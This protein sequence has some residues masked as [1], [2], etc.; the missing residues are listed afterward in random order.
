[1]R[2]MKSPLGRPEGICGPPGAEARG[3][4]PARAG[5]DGLKSHSLWLGHVQDGHAVPDVGAH[6]T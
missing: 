4:Q 3:S 5:W 2:E 6:V 1:M